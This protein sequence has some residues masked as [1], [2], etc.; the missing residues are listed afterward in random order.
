MPQVATHFEDLEQQAHA[1]RLGMW[2]FLASEALLF[3]GLFVLYAA[4]RTLHAAEFEVGVVHNAK[5]LGSTNTL[6]LLCSSFTV[7]SALR[8][9][10][11]GRR[12]RALSLLATTIALGLLFL[13]I[14]GI[15]YAKHFREGA[16]PGK[17]EFITLYFA[18]TGLH[19]LHVAIGM[20]IL[21]FVARGVARREIAPP[22]VHRLEVGA[23][24]W[25]LVDMIWIFLWPLF[26]LTPGGGGGS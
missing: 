25:H 16:F 23:I 2:V 24:Y 6:V 20:G 5:L 1:A 21:V 14:K 18:M 3:T 4:Y 15:E 7:A 10:R 22:F 8:V 12:G 19:A 13:G 17:D 26:Y 11:D 9:L